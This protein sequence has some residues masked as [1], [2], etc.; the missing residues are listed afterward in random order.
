MKKNKR[1]KREENCLVR[2]RKCRSAHNLIYK[3]WR[4]RVY[5]K[6]LIIHKNMVIVRESN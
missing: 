2:Q 1:S 3:I 4:F 5:S 6:R